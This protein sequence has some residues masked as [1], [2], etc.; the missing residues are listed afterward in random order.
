VSLFLLFF[1]P[2]VHAQEPA[3]YNDAFLQYNLRME[4]Y[5]KAHEEYVLR[6][7]QYMRF[8]T[9][10]SENDARAATVALL[11]TR[12]DVVISYIKA[13]KKRLEE[14]KGVTS[15]QKNTLTILLDNEISFFED[16]RSKIPSTGTLD[17]L[18][19]DSK[20]AQ[21]EFTKSQSLFYQSLF[22]VSDGKLTDLRTRLGDQFTLLKS[23][24]D[25]IRVET[26]PEYMFSTDKMQ[27]IDRF[28]FESDNK[29]LR[30]D[31]KKKL[32]EDFTT[33]KG[34]VLD[35]SEYNRRIGTLGES[36]QLLK[37]A[38]SFLKEIVNQIKKQ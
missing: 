16:H 25:T 4:D 6:R 30:S 14:T 19:A 31:D 33:L 9:L 34:G 1:V 3:T 29:I 17:D 32:A 37:E 12:D 7:S 28:I 15:E 5:D 36:Q 27:A 35:V 18:V 2:S 22:A 24:I 20:L 8:K 11:Q 10:Q 23:K 21:S 26:R 13:L 38:S